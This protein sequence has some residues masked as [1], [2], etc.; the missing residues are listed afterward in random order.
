MAELIAAFEKYIAQDKFTEEELM[1][2]KK[3]QRKLDARLLYIKLKERL[4]EWITNV[5]IPVDSLYYKII[6]MQLEPS[7]A[8]TIEGYE[9]SDDGFHISFVSILYLMEK[10]YIT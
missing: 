4:H 7:G 9:E 2:L 10:I 6:Y 3:C 5:G 8:K 1:M